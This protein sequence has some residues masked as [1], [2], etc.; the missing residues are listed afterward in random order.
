MVQKDNQKVAAI[1]ISI[2]L[3]LLLWIYVMGEQNPVQTRSVDNVRVSLENTEN[4]TRNNL[5]LLPR[6]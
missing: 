5:V 1:A 4:I 6:Q 3:A 2:F